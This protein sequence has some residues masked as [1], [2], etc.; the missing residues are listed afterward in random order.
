MACKHLLAL[1]LTIA[2]GGCGTTK[3]PGIE[4]REVP[5]PTPVACVK[6]DQIPA[7][8]EKVGSQ[9]S[10]DARHDLS[11]IAESALELR[12]WGQQLNALLAGCT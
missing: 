9:L 3:E 1:G 5:V 12:K 2:L 11:I 4:I 8:P 10:G 6:A 7:E